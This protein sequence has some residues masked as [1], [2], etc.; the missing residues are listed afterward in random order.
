MKKIN[1]EKDAITSAVFKRIQGLEDN[2]SVEEIY[3]RRVGYK[4]YFKHLKMNLE[5]IEGIKY[6]AEVTKSAKKPS[7]GIKVMPSAAKKA[8]TP[9]KE[10]KEGKV[11][12]P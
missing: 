9:K 12:A 10:T 3:S 1:L 6:P 4:E 5:R 11:A 8:P 2:D 7:K